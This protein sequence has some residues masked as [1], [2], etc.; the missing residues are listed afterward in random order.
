MEDLRDRIERGEY[1][2]GAQIPT[3]AELME[4]YG[5]ALGTLD[6]A[7]EVLRAEGFISTVHGLGTF[8]KSPPP[9]QTEPEADSERLVEVEHRLA[10][11]EAQVE[12]IHANLALGEQANGKKAA[13]G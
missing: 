11:L 3:K 13:A 5:V 4:S 10:R 6:R 7:L 12:N 1:A 2:T 8:A 9:K